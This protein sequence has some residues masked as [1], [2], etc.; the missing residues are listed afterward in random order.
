MFTTYSLTKTLENLKDT[1]IEHELYKKYDSF[2]KIQDSE[3]RST[4]EYY[5]DALKT[6]GMITIPIPGSEIAELYVD[7]LFHVGHYDI[8]EFHVAV[9]FKI[10]N[11]LKNKYMMVA[12][13]DHFGDVNMDGTPNSKNYIP[14]Y[15]R[16]C[17]SC[18][19]KN[20]MTVMEDGASQSP[21]TSVDME[22]PGV[23]KPHLPFYRRKINDA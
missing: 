17:V 18:I 15:M 16:L 19:L 4:V 14:G 12:D 22:K 5:N 10:I 21:Q 9:I 6:D 13:I 2:I 7:M 11:H 20:C 1:Y 23:S 8:Y 3:L